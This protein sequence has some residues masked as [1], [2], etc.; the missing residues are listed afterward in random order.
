MIP[1]ISDTVTRP[2]EAMLQAMLNADTGDDVFGQDPS[3]NRLEAFA[4]AMFGKEAALFCP[5]GTMTNQIAIK[6]HTSPLDELIC[7]EYSHVYQY[8]TGGY[9]FHSG[10]SVN[11]LQGPDG[12]ITPAQIE[13]AVKAPYDWLPRSRLVVIENTTNK[14]GGAWYSL[15]EMA[16]IHQTCKNLGLRLHMDG[17]RFFNAAVEAG[18][19]TEDTGPLFDSISICLSKGLGAPVGSLL[20]ADRGSIKEARRYRKV[21]GGG[22][23]QAGYLAAAGLYAL[24]HHI[25]RLRDDH[26][27]ARKLAS[28]L[29]SLAYVSRVYPVHTNIVMFDI[30][31]GKADFFCRVLEA[32]GITASAFGPQT[33]RLVTHLDINDRHIEE[34]EAVFRSL[35]M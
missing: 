2:T 35:D 7:H 31:T 18:Y 28:M 6:L 17:A 20:I 8:E 9:A 11:L 3:V 21:M 1:L 15:D 13:E 14:G 4:A 16:A 24:R 33:V 29:N 34:A 12:K 27:R 30:N 10:V 26:A 32:R 22:M 23:R 19:K 5:S 25:D